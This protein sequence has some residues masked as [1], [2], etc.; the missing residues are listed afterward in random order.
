MHHCRN[1]GIDGTGL[2]VDFQG[3]SDNQDQD[4]NICRVFDAVWN[5]SE[6]IKEVVEIQFVFWK[7]G[8]NTVS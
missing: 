3:T 7:L 5:C 4:D 6:N 1:T 2:F 8:V